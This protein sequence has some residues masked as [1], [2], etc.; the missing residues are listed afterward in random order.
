[1]K[2]IFIT[3]N[4]SHHKKFNLGW[5][6]AVMVLSIISFLI[7]TLFLVF[8]NSESKDDAI[9]INEIQLL[10]KFDLMLMRTAELEGQVN[11]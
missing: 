6:T 8:K 1:M 9:S 10:N 4:G 2:L 3:D 5:R 7:I 11:V